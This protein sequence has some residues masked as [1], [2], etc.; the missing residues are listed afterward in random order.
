MNA[1][2]QKE[3]NPLLEIVA[4]R[5]SAINMTL[6]GVDEKTLYWRLAEDE[7][8]NFYYQKIFFTPPK[9]PFSH[10]LASQ[11]AAD[12]IDSSTKQ[13]AWMFPKHF[14]IATPAF[15][16]RYWIARSA[17]ETSPH[18]AREIKT[19]T[20]LAHRDPD[21]EHFVQ[22]ALN[23]FQYADSFQKKET[24]EHSLE[25]IILAHRAK[26]VA[27]TA[28]YLAVLKIQS[29]KAKK[30]GE[31]ERSYFLNKA[32]YCTEQTLLLRKKILE[33]TQQGEE[34]KALLCGIVALAWNNVTECYR[35]V[36]ACI[37]SK[38]RTSFFLFDQTSQAAEQA[39]IRMQWL[40]ENITSTLNTTRAAHLE[41]AF[42]Y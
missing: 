13:F 7:V 35:K 11:A 1:S 32:A 12:F 26:T 27:F 6:A 5:E 33:A 8:T 25:N 23:E 28:A 18:F 17:I 14:L 10:E 29:L 2:E 16:Y 38:N 34:K 20:L 37:S 24:E 4:Y 21:G 3:Q 30:N 19:L 41:R 22:E 15:H 39:A 36:V 31:E 40:L 42:F 9:I